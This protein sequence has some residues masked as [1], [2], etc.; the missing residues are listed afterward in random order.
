MLF[1]ALLMKIYR[2]FHCSD[3]LG[4]DFEMNTAPIP[5]QFFVDAPIM[6]LQ[7]DGFQIDELLPPLSR[8]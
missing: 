3:V 6:R 1:P 7:I 8:L 4:S 5:H 2:I